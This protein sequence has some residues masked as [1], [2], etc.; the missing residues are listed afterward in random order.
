MD[1][2]DLVRIA[3]PDD[4][5]AIYFHLMYELGADNGLGIP[6]TPAKV[7]QQVTKCCTGDM[8]IAG[9]MESRTDGI[10]ASI[11]IRAAEAW[12]SN[13]T[14]IGQLW[15]FVAPH[16]RHGRKLYD[17]LFQ[18][19]EWHRQDMTKRLGY[20]VTG[21]NVVMS[22]SR[23]PAKA[24]LWRRYGTQTG[25]VFWNRGETLEHQQDR[26]GDENRDIDHDPGEPG[27]PV[28]LQRPNSPSRSGSE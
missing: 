23:L 10:V 11:G 19:F 20:S 17:P 22:L 15:L 3:T 25:A 18:F 12:F 16:A 2:P 1:K 9:I 8:G 26:H 27:G 13:Q 24:R 4:I 21:E 28:R 14:I 7:L 5:Q 6:P